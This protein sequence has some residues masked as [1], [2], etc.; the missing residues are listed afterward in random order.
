[1]NVPTPSVQLIMVVKAVDARD[2]IISHYGLF[3]RFRID[4][5]WRTGRQCCTALRTVFSRSS[6]KTTTVG[7]CYELLF[8]SAGSCIVYV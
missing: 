4:G 6:V 3:F 1:M 8:F 5:C 7:V 2:E